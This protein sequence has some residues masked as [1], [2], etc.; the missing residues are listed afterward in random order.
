MKHICDYGC[1]QEAKHQFKNGK[2]CCSKSTMKCPAIREKFS[3]ENNPFFG[4]H[5]SKKSLA[6][7]SENGKLSKRLRIPFEK[8]I[9]E[10]K[11]RKY[12]I[13]S[14]EDEYQNQFSELFLIC[15][16]G[17]KFKVTWS[18]F[19]GG[20]ECPECSKEKAYKKRRTSFEKIIKVVEGRKYKLLSK[21][22]EYQ[23]QFSYLWFMCPKGHKFRTTWC[24][25]H[26][27]KEGCLECSIERLK[28]PSKETR[29]R[30]R[31]SAIKRIENQVGQIFPNYNIEACK[32]ID[33]YGKENNYNFQHAEN[34][35]E[36]FIKEL[37]Y[38]VDGYDKEKNVVIEIDEPFHYDKDGN[39]KERD[40]QRQKEIEDFLECKF[41]RLLIN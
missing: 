20:S 21:E 18:N 29:R 6:K 26:N 32:L 23:N 4:K 17:H 24:C 1:G 34:G 39:L 10:V 19:K 13:L 27:S 31:I 16:K 3:G 12:K 14:K 15:P 41:I 8:I 25:F 40:L 35:G 22:D 36:F 30:M 37:G 9:E 5:H 38:W 33:E 11:R 7:I 28:N 2:W